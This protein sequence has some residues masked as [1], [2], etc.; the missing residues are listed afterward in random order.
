[1]F[2]FI[3]I[4]THSL[5]FEGD[6]VCLLSSPTGDG[7]D[8]YQSQSLLTAD[9]VFAQ[10]QCPLTCIRF[11]LPSHYS[12]QME[13]IHPFANHICT[14]PLVLTHAFQGSQL[15]PL[16]FFYCL[17]FL[18]PIYQAK[19]PDSSTPSP[20][21][22]KN[23]LWHLVKAESHGIQIGEGHSIG[24][25][26]LLDSINLMFTPDIPPVRAVLN[27]FL[28]AHKARTGYDLSIENVTD[29]ESFYTEMLPPT[30]NLGFIPVPSR[31]FI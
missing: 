18:E 1:M 5:R 15:W 25:K 7:G 2:R 22:S 26:T 8:T 10:T 17:P 9:L 13:Y 27:T 16:V 23:T 12:D 3:S 14:Y 11:L 20:P 21:A 30:S 31:D 19:R 6:I 4:N 24:Q 28:A 29:S